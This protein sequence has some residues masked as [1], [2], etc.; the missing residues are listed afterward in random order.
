M[1]KVTVTIERITPSPQGDK[2]E[3]IVSL[4]QDCASNKVHKVLD[5]ALTLYNAT[6][7]N[8]GRFVFK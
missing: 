2:S 3:T 8:T 5:S 7:P 4:S 1:I 6:T